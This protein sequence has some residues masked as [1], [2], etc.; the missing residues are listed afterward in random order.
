M[1]NFSKGH[2][3][4]NNIDKAQ[5]ECFET[6]LSFRPDIS[7][8]RKVKRIIRWMKPTS[9]NR[10]ISIICNDNLMRLGAKIGY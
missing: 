2:I 8:L 9:E 3:N 6:N 10:I 7:F 4:H 1:I 5:R